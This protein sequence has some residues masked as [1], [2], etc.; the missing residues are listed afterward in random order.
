[1]RKQEEYTFS[2]FLRKLLK[3]GYPEAKVVLK[4]FF[5]LPLFM[6]TFTALY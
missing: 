2:V 4:D 3:A 6:E 5:S 1:M